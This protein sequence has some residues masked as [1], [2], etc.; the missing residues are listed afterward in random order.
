MPPSIFRQ[1]LPGC[2]AVRPNKLLLPGS[3]WRL[4]RG[5]LLLLLLLPLSAQ[6]WDVHQVLDS[7]RSRF[8]RIEDYQVDLNVS[9]KMPGLRMPR[10]KMT[11]TFKQPDKTRLEAR[12]FAMVPR[13]GLALSPDSLV[14]QLR[15]LTMVGDTLLNGHHCLII[16]G[17]ENGPDD[18]TL[19][20]EILVDRKLWLVRGIT[21]YLE[22]HEV[23]RLWTEYVEVAPGIHM[24]GET[25]LRFQINER[26]IRGRSRNHRSY[27]Y[28]PDIQEPVFDDA[29]D[30]AGEASI[31]FSNYRIN[32]GIPDEFFHEGEKP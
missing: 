23:F 2:T 7:L 24:P 28:D 4:R 10:K 11:L 14:Q 15:D 20:A 13:R 21:T 22:N 29:G 3:P 25:H 17:V 1:L 26:F 8:Q 32:M 19:L 27:I 5:L 6:T 31:V 9:L 30:L 18:L 12:G 16:R